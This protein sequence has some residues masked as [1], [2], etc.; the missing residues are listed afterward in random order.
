[1]IGSIIGDI[2]GS[3]YEFTGN[4]NPCVELFPRGSSFTDDTVMMVATADAIL[5][6]GGYGESFRRYGE[7]YPYPMGGYGTRFS[8]WLR[9]E[10]PQ[11]YGSWGNG[12]AMRVAP[13]GWAFDSLED[14]MNEAKKSA[15]VSHD[16]PE[17]IKGAESMVAAIWMARH[18]KSKEE[19][20]EFIESH[21]GYDLSRSIPEIRS[22]YGFDESC[23]GTVPEALSA[24]LQ[25]DGY[26]EAIRTAISLG[27][28]AD[29][30]ACITG[31]VAE[32]FYSEIPCGFISQAEE[33]LPMELLQIVKKF[34]TKFGLRE[35][36]SK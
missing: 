33:I 36:L 27:G 12:A 4:K 7:K 28:D 22:H 3:T 14:A 8:C 10:N 2:A 13:I 5:H 26:E 15:I 16:H 18:G 29:T 20:R 24:F 30:L 11:P 21:F 32:A 1:M 6:G 23:Q 9:E 17:G 31:G 34:R 19:I 35:S 25:S